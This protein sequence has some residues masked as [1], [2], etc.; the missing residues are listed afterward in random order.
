MVRRRISTGLALISASLLLIFP[1]CV[2]ERETTPAPR[3]IIFMIGDGM[4]NSIVSA[5]RIKKGGVTGFLN[6]DRMPVVGLVRTSSASHLITDSA[7]SG[8]AM[9]SGFKTYNG[10]IGVNAEGKNVLSI[11]EAAMSRGMAGG[12]VATSP[13]THATPAS[14][15][16][17]VAKRSEGN[18]IAEGLLANKIDVLLG[19]GY[20]FFIPKPEEG[21]YRN[22]ERDL[23]RE[24]REAG[25]AVCL[26][27]EEMAS[28]PAGMILGLFAR[29]SMTTEPPEPSLAEMAAEALRRLEVRKEGFFLMVEGS[30]IDYAAHDTDLE[31][32]LNQTLKFDEAVATA[33]AFAEKDGRT[34][35]IVTADHE[36]GGLV[37]TGGEMD[38]SKINVVWAW[39]NHNGATVPLYAFGPGAGEF[40]GFKENTDIPKIFA[41]LLGIAD[42]PKIVE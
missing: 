38:G 42:F 19:G 25:Y 28:A 7:A 34:L 16:S 20:G 40:A 21:S 8:T 31:K 4:S 24:A 32:T 12:L 39:D 15:G 10:A 26:T 14:F 23:I 37:I 27:R 5:A 2:P 29:S 41:R 36:T 35:V 13:I 33:L 9:S 18:R 17:H 30:Q 3:N 11:L 22:D 1:A 6:M